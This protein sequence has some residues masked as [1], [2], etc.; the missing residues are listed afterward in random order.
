MSHGPTSPP[1]DEPESP[2]R[3][4]LTSP[5]PV[6]VAIALGL[7]VGWAFRPA[8]LRLGRPEPDVGWSAV[9]LV[10]FLAAIVGG[11]AYLTWAALHRDGRR[12]PGDQAV[13]RLVLGKACALVGA[14]LLGG[15]VGY[16]IGHL[17]LA[18]QP[19]AT[20]RLVRSSVAALGA[21]GLL[22]ASLLLE[23]AC[24]VRRDD[25]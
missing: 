4:D 12:L 10:W 2:G 24:R 21:A 20:A 15:Y 1:P 6:V 22:L 17:N 23:R 7:V 3:V 18:G 25:E 19:N 14:L 9:A 16:A 13:N 11:A 8:T 5:G